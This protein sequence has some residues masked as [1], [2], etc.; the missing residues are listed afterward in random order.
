MFK[1][2][3]RLKH[4]NTCNLRIPLGV[5]QCQSDEMVD[6]RLVV[7]GHP[8]V[9]QIAASRVEAGND[10]Q[11]GLGTCLRRLKLLTKSHGP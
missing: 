2:G 9:P 5:V 11:A 8:D 1:S 6:H 3:V 7:Y 4:N 10:C